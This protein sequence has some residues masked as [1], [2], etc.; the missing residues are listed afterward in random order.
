VKLKY[1]AGI[2]AAESHVAFAR[3]GLYGWLVALGWVVFPFAVATVLH[4]GDAIWAQ[5]RIQG[6]RVPHVFT[7]QQETVGRIEA[8]IALAVL[9]MFQ[10]VGTVLFYRRAQ[11]NGAKVAAPPLWAWAAVLAGVLA[12]AAWFF[13]TG[14]FDIG[15]C[16]AGL[17]SAA[18]TVG[19]EMVVEKLGRE[20][21]CGVAQPGHSPLFL[22][23]FS[24]QS[25]Q[26]PLLYSE[27]GQGP[28]HYHIPD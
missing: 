2:Y 13:G 6:L 25:G 20:F 9:V 21:V 26:A 23:G 22:G 15:G 19:C 5:L 7:A 27:S 16:L 8:V 24:A 1:H 12:N 28:V 10:L 14:Y 18:L 11:L 17:S 3:A 4:P